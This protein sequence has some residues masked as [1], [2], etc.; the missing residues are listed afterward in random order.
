M[1]L[2]RKKGG[3]VEAQTQVLWQTGI[4]SL[5]ARTHT[6]KILYIHLNLSTQEAE[7]GRFR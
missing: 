3:D 1:R 2:E 6:H 4:L 5:S 7:I